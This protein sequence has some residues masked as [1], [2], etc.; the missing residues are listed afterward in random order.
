MLFFSK[1]R[2]E[3]AEKKAAEEAR[4][5]EAR[6]ARERKEKE[7]AAKKAALAGEEAALRAAKKIYEKAQSAE[8]SHNYRE[9]E[10]LYEE[11]FRQGYYPAGMELCIYYQEMAEC[12]KRDLPYYN[13]TLVDRC[14]KKAYRWASD[15]IAAAER[16]AGKKRGLA[17]EKSI[18]VFDTENVMQDMHQ[19]LAKMD[20]YRRGSDGGPEA[21][22]RH[23]ALAGEFAGRIT[24]EL[25]EGRNAE[26]FI[27]LEKKGSWSVDDPAPENLPE[28]ILDAGRYYA[29]LSWRYGTW[30]EKD[31]EKAFQLFR[32]MDREGYYAGAYGLAGCYENGIGTEADP[33]EAIRLYLKASWAN[34]YE[35]RAGCAKALVKAGREEEWV[36]SVIGQLT[37]VYYAPAMF[38]Y[39]MMLEKGFGAEKDPKKAVEVITDADTLWKLYK[40]DQ[41]DHTAY[42]PEVMDFLTEHYR[43]MIREG[44]DPE[45]LYRMSADRDLLNVERHGSTEKRI[46]ILEALRETSLKEKAE[47]ALYAFYTYYS[48]GVQSDTLKFTYDNANY[49]VFYGRTK[50]PEEAFKLGLQFAGKGDVRAMYQTGIRLCRGIGTQ[51]DPAGAELWLKKAQENG[52]PG[53]DAALANMD[54]PEDILES[55]GAITGVKGNHLE[56]ARAFHLGRDL[57]FDEGKMLM[58]LDAAAKEGEKEASE[59]L[60]RFYYS[61]PEFL[62]NRGTAFDYAKKAGEA[63][64]AEGYLLCGQMCEEWG[65]SSSR[66]ALEYYQMAERLGSGDARVRAKELLEA[67]KESYEKG[68]EAF[69]RGAYRAAYN[70]WYP[71]FRQ[72]DNRVV[73]PAASML[74]GQPLPDQDD[75]ACWI[76]TRACELGEI[77]YAGDAARAYWFSPEYSD[78]N[79]VIAWA[80]KDPALTSDECYILAKACDLAGRHSDYLHRLEEAAEG[81]C[82]MAQYELAIHHILQNDRSGYI[83]GELYAKRASQ[84]PDKTDPAGIYAGSVPETE[85]LFD[86]LKKMNM[87]LTREEEWE[88]LAK[89]EEMEERQ[90]EAAR[91]RAEAESASSDKPASIFGNP[92][93]NYRMTDEEGNVYNYDPA[94]GRL[95]GEGIDG[96]ISL[97]PDEM[98]RRRAEHEVNKMV[99][100]FINR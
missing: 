40:S 17:F 48:R 92:F 16:Q 42:I 7:E 70:L 8:F 66:Y 78:E 80:Q 6:E 12:R 38:V 54:D 28:G 86:R 41:K 30:S 37:S 34:S 5:R 11:A 99:E 100:D 23:A 96:Y 93:E 15:T 43:T 9:A 95:T 22:A 88:A 72:K 33:E 32:A 56:R 71:C 50:I 82:Y 26:Y 45:Y 18:F 67:E 69:R 55:N 60:A 51:K 57:V 97:S 3:A 52:F 19:E 94:T 76:F 63:G 62:Q 91:Q 35:Y 74:A 89:L 64:S 36:K 49:C 27:D 58:E 4:E 68:L 25:E 87:R 46:A 61:G 14:Y 84:N 73:L 85:K 79:L 10:E 65:V 83:W 1:K 77:K 29:G 2:R 59:L 44:T 53:T 81:G 75:F 47:K 21:A 31:P 20:L 13:K 90:R 24:D 98:R 39:A